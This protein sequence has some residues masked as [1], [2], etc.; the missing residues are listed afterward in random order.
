[1]WDE[2]AQRLVEAGHRV[3]RYD[4][5]GHGRTPALER[6]VELQDFTA[7]LGA[8]LQHLKIAAVAVVGFSLGALV[9]RAYAVQSRTADAPGFAQ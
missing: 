8:L 6:A 7:Q 5:L 9:A 3:V 2:H 1:M 4:L